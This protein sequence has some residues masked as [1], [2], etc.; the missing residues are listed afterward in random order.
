MYTCETQ[1]VEE[2]NAES[3]SEPGL[4][5]AA[6]H[7]TWWDWLFEPEHTKL[8]ESCVVRGFLLSHW[9]FFSN[10]GFLTP[11]PRMDFNGTISLTIDKCVHIYKGDF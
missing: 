4:L 1:E 5:P 9:G 11:C 7:F 3:L 8:A 2:T 10:Q 6:I